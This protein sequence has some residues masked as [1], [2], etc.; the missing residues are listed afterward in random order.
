MRESSS[1]RVVQ[2]QES[3]LK[4]GRRFESGRGRWMNTVSRIRPE[5]WL[6]GSH[7]LRSKSGGVSEWLMEP[8]PKTG[9]R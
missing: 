6:R 1:V 8:V 2:R 9:G 7:R 4:E 3:L 5:Y